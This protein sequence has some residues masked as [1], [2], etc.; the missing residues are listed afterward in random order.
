MHD[1]R[2]RAVI[3]CVDATDVMAA[4]AATNFPKRPGE[5]A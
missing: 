1:R 2:P 4:V 5:R 3:Q